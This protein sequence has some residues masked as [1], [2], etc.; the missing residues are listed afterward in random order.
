MKKK[1]ILRVLDL[2]K[3]TKFGYLKSKI[4]HFN[5]L[6]KIRNE[7]HATFTPICIPNTPYAKE[8]AQQG[9]REAAKESYF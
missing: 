7:L 5:Y 6:T 1:I 2:K 8:K 9:L 3:A 4:F